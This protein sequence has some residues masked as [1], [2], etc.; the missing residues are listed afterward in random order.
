MKEYHEL[1]LAGVVALAGIGIAGALL[2]SLSDHD[3]KGEHRAHNSTNLAALAGTPEP[4]IKQER[5]ASFVS[6]SKSDQTSSTAASSNNGASTTTDTSFSSYS[7]PSTPPTFQVSIL[8]G[9]M[10]SSVSYLSFAAAIS[11]SVKIRPRDSCSGKS[12]PKPTRK[13]SGLI[14]PYQSTPD[15]PNNVYLSHWLD[16]HGGSN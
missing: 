1:K 5:D 15:F 7:R 10:S 2:A 3:G 6:A 8:L 16:M 13:M 12:S 4:P 14:I 11:F 9:D